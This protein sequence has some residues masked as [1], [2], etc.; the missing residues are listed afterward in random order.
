VVVEFQINAISIN[1]NKERGGLKSNFEKPSFRLKNKKIP[2][3][4]YR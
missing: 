1:K 4:E 3:P 2:V